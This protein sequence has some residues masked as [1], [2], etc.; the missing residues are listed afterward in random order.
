[1]NF[2]GSIQNAKSIIKIEI[3]GGKIS[4][5]L[6]VFFIENI[7]EPNSYTS[8]PLNP[9]S[10]TIWTADKKYENMKVYLSK[11]Y[12]GN[13]TKNFTDKTPSCQEVGTVNLK[14]YKPGIYQVAIIIEKGRKISTYT[15]NNIEIKENDCEIL[16]IVLPK[17]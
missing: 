3:G 11:T 2:S 7:I 12:I 14:K 8:A 4:D 9:G 5:Y 16:E 15:F 6:D 17:K 10:L 1:M 13:F